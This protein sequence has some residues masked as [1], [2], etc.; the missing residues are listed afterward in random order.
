MHLVRIEL[1]EPSEHRF[2]VVGQNDL[3]VHLAHGHPL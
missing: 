1:A 3:N 2:A